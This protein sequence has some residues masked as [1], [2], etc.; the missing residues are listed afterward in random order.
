MAAQYKAV[1]SE[2]ADY[3]LLMALRDNRTKRH[4]QGL[5]YVEG[6]RQLTQ[7]LAYGWHF[8]SLIFVHEQSLS[9]WA[10]GVLEAAQ[11]DLH[12]ALPYPLQAKLSAKT[13]P[14]E[15][16]AIL[17]MP[18][19][20]FDRITFKGLPL[21]VVVDRSSNPGN[22]GTIIRSCDALGVD[23]LVMTG[24]AVDPYDPEV[25][26]ATTGSLFALPVIRKASAK[27]L[28]PLLERLRNEYGDVQ[29]VGTSAQADKP[30]YEG[31]FWRP[32]VLM[33]GNETDG[34]SQAYEQMADVMLNIPMQGSASS[35]NVAC[36]T[37]IVLY[38][39]ARQRTR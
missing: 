37:S 11:A 12:Y 33:I 34:L 31:N 2:N 27:E 22:L 4:K 13:D 5:F 18:A 19:D 32:T 14:S 9:D 21:I 3:Q 24:H 6:V 20:S 7:A 17:E 28:A 29:L 26:A 39:V 15:L 25:I 38:E 16:I 30:L 10:Q 35:L 1:H 8:R 36:A 23:G